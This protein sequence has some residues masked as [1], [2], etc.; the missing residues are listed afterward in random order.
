[1]TMATNGVEPQ[2]SGL[3]DLGQFL[4]NILIILLCL[5]VFWF[6]LAFS[7]VNNNERALFADMLSGSAERPFVT[8]TLIPWLTRGIAGIFP[9]S[10]HTAASDSARTSSFIGDWLTH[11]NIPAALALEG[12]ISLAIQ[13]GSLIGFAH[14]IK[15]LLTRVYQAPTFFA[16]LATL[17]ALFGLLPMLLFGYIYDLPN[18]FLCTLALYWIATRKIASY[19]IVFILAIMNKETAVLL[20][21]PSVLLFWDFKQ[22]S[23][24]KVCTGILA[25]VAVYL[26]VRLPINAAFK[27][28]PG[29]AFEFNIDEHLYVLVNHPVVWGI[30]V[31]F[32][33]GVIGLVFHGWREKPALAMLG[34][35]PM[36]PLIGLFVVSGFPFEIRVFYEVYAAGFLGLIFSLAGKR[37][38]I[39]SKPPV[40]LDG[41]KSLPGLFGRQEK[42]KES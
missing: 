32:G 12:F 1:L 34:A 38:P 14:A 10:I 16:S 8:R 15:A 37:I 40:T 29:V 19:A 28:N 35:L 39:Q 41:I 20:I 24:V 26:A 18:L 7:G 13:L 11:I 4:L 17:T 9:E 30:S 42:L 5:G 25:Q 31:L 36:L 2:K 3:K 33:L 6:F 22:P 23:L 21:V 27:T